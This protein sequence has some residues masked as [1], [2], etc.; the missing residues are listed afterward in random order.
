M[1]SLRSDSLDN[2]CAER[3]MVYIAHIA[4]QNSVKLNLLCFDALPDSSQAFALH[5][6]AA[7][8]PPS[9]MPPHHGRGQNYGFNAEALQTKASGARPDTGTCDGGA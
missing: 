5:R 9:R 1:K 6:A 4:R 7:G 2:L 3:D 8:R